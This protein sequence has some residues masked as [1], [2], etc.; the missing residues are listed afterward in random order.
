MTY[1]LQDVVVSICDYYKIESKIIFSN[2]R[3]YQSIKLRQIFSYVSYEK[4][5]LSYPKIGNFMFSHGFIAGRNHSSV[6]HAKN[7]CEKS[8]DIYPEFKNEVLSIIEK[9][10]PNNPMIPR[11]VNLLELCKSYSRTV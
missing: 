3:K 4:C 2:S 6:L 5:N 9:L 10:E 7:E 8:M 11:E 1:T